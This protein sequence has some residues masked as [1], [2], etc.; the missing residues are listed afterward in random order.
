MRNERAGHG[1]LSDPECAVEEEDQTR[2]AMRVLFVGLIAAAIPG[3][4]IVLLWFLAPAEWP[5]RRAAAP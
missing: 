2:L 4:N 1:G 3:A 5:A